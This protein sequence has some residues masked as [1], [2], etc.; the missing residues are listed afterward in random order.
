MDKTR[1]QRPSALDLAAIN[2]AYWRERTREI[3]D[4]AGMAELIGRAALAPSK[5]DRRTARAELLRA[6]AM[7]DYFSRSSARIFADQLISERRRDE[8]SKP[9]TQA[10]PSDNAGPK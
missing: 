9:V 3:T 5:R 1:R 6:L 10:E 7:S 4:N 8:K 2:L